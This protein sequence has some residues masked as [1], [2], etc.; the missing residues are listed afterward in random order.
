MLLNDVEIFLIAV[1]FQLSIYHGDDYRLV[2]PVP[3]PP[4]NH[5]KSSPN[6]SGGGGGKI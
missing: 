6:V 4:P 5:T 2:Y 1:H 3:L